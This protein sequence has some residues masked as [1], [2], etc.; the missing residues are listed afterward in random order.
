MSTVP[1]MG[2]IAAK[3][4]LVVPPCSTLLRDLHTGRWGTRVGAA[5][6]PVYVKYKHA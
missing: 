3:L 1:P 6:A 5:D 2:L 4:I